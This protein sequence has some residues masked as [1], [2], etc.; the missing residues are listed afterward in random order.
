MVGGGDQPEPVPPAQP[1]DHERAGGGAVGV[2]PEAVRGLV[3]AAAGLEHLDQPAEPRIVVVPVVVD[4]GRAG[5]VRD[6][7]RR[8]LGVR[9][10]PA[11]QPVRGGGALGE[12]GE[13]RGAPGHVAVDHVLVAA[14]GRGP[15][16]PVQRD[17]PA[18]HV[19][20]VGDLL[21]APPLVGRGVLGVVGDRPEVVLVDVP[22]VA[23][24]VLQRGL[25]TGRAAA[26]QGVPVQVPPVQLVVL[27]AGPHPVALGL[28]AGP[29]PAA[30][31]LA[32]VRAQRRAPRPVGGRGA[33]AL[34]DAQHD[35]AG[36]VHA[37]PDHRA[38]VVGQVRALPAAEA[39]GPVQGPL[40][41][42]VA[43]GGQHD[44]GAGGGQRHLL[45]GGVGPAERDGREPAVGPQPCTAASQ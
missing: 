25:V 26:D 43:L 13:D 41:P 21:D 30:G 4:H 3:V 42:A 27:V 15:L 18:R 17:E 38:V 19:Q 14:V 20:Q 10:Q 28:P 32:A 39:L 16:E 35:L 36:A 8:E 37:V 23:V 12:R 1:V 40:Q 2:L 45:Q 33:D 31:L 34:D 7:D 5:V 24:E 6:G 9:G 11:P 44:P 22:G 29:G